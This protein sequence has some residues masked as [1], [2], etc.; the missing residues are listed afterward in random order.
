MATLHKVTELTKRALL[1]FTI[2]GTSAI[3]LIARNNIAGD[4]VKISDTLYQWQQNVSPFAKITYDIVTN[5]FSF[6]TNYLTDPAILT[7]PN[8]PDQPGAIA[9]ATNFFTNLSADMSDID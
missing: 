9:S 1:I 6:I 7:A 5:N 4:P 2:V 8:L 3:L